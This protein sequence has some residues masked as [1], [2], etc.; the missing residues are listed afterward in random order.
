MPEVF[1]SSPVDFYA[2]KGYKEGSIIIGEMIKL[3]EEKYSVIVTITLMENELNT[4]IPG[5]SVEILDNTKTLG[6]GYKSIRKHENFG[7][8]TRKYIWD[9]PVI[10]GFSEDVQI[11][12]I[13]IPISVNT[14][15]EELK[16]RV[17]PEEL[18]FE[19]ISVDFQAK[20]TG[21]RYI[22]HEHFIITCAIGIIWIVII[23]IGI[24]YFLK[25]KIKS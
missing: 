5:I 21:L 9:I 8:K 17:S 23:E 16:I 11:V 19:Q 4:H 20:L 22:L 13:N 10:F 12:K 15:S 7:S 14:N 18:Q 24:T 2:E 25:S 3:E 1:Q 6:K